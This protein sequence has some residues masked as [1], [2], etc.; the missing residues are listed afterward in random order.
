MDF[1]L[2]LVRFQKWV[3]H[4]SCH[5]EENYGGMVPRSGRDY[6]SLQLEIQQEILQ[7]L[8]YTSF[9]PQLAVKYL[10]MIYLSHSPG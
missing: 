3:L 6:Y 10:V 9:L 4:I 7:S 8:L 5:M 2:N 1:S